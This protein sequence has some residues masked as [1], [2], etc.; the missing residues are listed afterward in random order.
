[1]WRGILA[2]NGANVARELRAAAAILS[3]IAEEAEK[4]DAS[5]L[6]ARF[7]AAASAVR[8]LDANDSDSAC[9]Q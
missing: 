6:A 2:S 5:S 1:M 7:A 3:S 8:L 9:V 4:G